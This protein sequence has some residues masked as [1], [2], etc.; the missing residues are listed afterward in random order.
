MP[1]KD[2]AKA[3]AVA[4]EASR[5]YKAKKRVEKYGPNAPD[6][7]GRHGKHVRGAQH[8]KWNGQKIVSSHGYI[9]L[10]VGV[11][12]PLADPNGYAYE[13]LLVVLTSNTL[14]AYLLREEPDKWVVHHRNEDKTDNRIE[15]LQV[16]ERADHNRLHNTVRERDALGRFTGKHAAGRLLDGREWNEF[17]KVTA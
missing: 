16:I 3:K 13:H 2:P 1:Y 12:H 17:P 10:R 7:R 9:K 15:N 5:R 4:R 14:G 6:Q 11:D 8:H